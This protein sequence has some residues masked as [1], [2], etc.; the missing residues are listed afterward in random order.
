MQ[1]EHEIIK[2]KSDNPDWV[3]ELYDQETG[4]FLCYYKSTKEKKTIKRKKRTVDNNQINQVP[5]S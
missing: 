4:L 1:T 5:S 2:I 3:W